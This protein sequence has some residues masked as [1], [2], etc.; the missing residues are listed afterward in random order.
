MKKLLG[1][2]LA[3][4]S[5]GVVGLGSEAQAMEHKSN[6]SVLSVSAAP[7]WSSDRY[8]RRAYGRRSVRTT[9]RSRVV[10][11]G[12]RVYRET[13]VVRYLPNGRLLDTRIIRRVRIA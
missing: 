3:L 12:R 4:A 7:Q 13:Y 10:R 2:V 6:T 1:V 9:T 5:I 11:Y 8:Q